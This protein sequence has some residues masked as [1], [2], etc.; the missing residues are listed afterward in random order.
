[1]FEF[2]GCLFDKHKLNDGRSDCLVL[3]SANIIVREIF[4]I[5]Y[6]QINQTKHRSPCMT[7]SFH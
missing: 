4:F 3:E 1:M 2:F 5:S 6:F 7:I